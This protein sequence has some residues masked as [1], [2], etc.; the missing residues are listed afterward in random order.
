M[1]VVNSELKDGGRLVASA[2]NFENYEQDADHRTGVIN[3][4]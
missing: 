2:Y 4:D 3:D 1:S